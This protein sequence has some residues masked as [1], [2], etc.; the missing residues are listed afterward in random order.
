MRICARE[1]VPARFN[2]ICT[3]QLIYS[4]LY[5]NAAASL[6]PRRYVER[7]QKNHM[8]GVA[9]SPLRPISAPSRLRAVAVRGN[10]SSRIRRLYESWIGSL[11]A[12]FWKQ[13]CRVCMRLRGRGAA[14]H[15]AT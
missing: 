15:S 6:H 11:P 14:V 3:L 9:S 13:T 7:Q 12:G 5:G 8:A 4:D 1:S 10:K 2:G